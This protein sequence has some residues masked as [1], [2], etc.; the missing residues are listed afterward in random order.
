MLNEDGQRRAGEKVE[1]LFRNY[2][3][4]FGEE[5]KPEVLKAKLEARIQKDKDDLL[6][7]LLSFRSRNAEAGFSTDDC[8]FAIKLMNHLL[9][10]VTEEI[11]ERPS[12]RRKKPSA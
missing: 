2:K 7:D 12:G 11:L 1:R 10:P 9:E 5:L 4:V 3:T 8:F 6:E